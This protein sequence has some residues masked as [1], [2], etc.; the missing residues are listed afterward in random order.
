MAWELQEHYLP[1]IENNLYILG[2]SFCARALAQIQAFD[3]RM[4]KHG[5]PVEKAT[6][7]AEVLYWRNMKKSMDD[8]VQDMMEHVESQRTC[9]NGAWK[10]YA[11]EHGYIEISTSPI[12]PEE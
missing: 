2:R 4:E 10:A 5:C 12:D 8:L 7:I 11:D 3:V 6:R 1:I 9:S